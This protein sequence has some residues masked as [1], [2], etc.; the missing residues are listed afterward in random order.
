MSAE[1]AI[2]GLV[3]LCSFVSGAM[4]G[5]GSVIIALTLA[6]HFYSIEWMVPRLVALNVFLNG[7]LVF[8]HRG[9]VAWRML[10][11]RLIPIMGLGAGVGVLVQA[12]LAGPTLK[13]I[14]G[15]LVVVLSAVELYRLK[16]NTPPAVGG[17]NRAFVF[18]AGVMHGIYA[19]GGPM[20]VYALGKAGLD[21]TT[22]RSTLAMVWLA[23]NVALTTVFVLDGRLDGA[24]AIDVAWLLVPVFFA[25]VVGELLHRRVDER[26]FR[27]VLFCLLFVAGFALL[28]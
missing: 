24:A 27:I 1:L 15:A 23:M 19:S 2:F 8:A 16:T 18:G 28:V 5:F 4:A 10:L 17:A 21:R 11:T 6:S 13:T 22:F 26:G 7:Y 9:H 3:V 25:T 14:F 20:L 12:Q